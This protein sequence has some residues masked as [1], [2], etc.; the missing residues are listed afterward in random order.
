[1]DRHLPEQLKIAINATPEG[2]RRAADRISRI[3]HRYR[4]T[5]YEEVNPTSDGVV[6]LEVDPREAVRVLERNL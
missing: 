1:V 2:A 6:L 3:A 5:I 4:E